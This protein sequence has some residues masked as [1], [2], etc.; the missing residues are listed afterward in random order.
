MII[1]ENKKLVRGSTFIAGGVCAGLADYYGLRKGDVQAAFVI[2]S[3]L[4][5]FPAVIYIVLWIVL[6]K[7]K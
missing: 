7:D 3:L 2:S 5:G 1:T 6:P 4:L